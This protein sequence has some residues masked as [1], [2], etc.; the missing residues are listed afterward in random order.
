MLEELA[1]MG[2]IQY[3][4]TMLRAMPKPDIS[5]MERKCKMCGEPTNTHY[6]PICRLR[7]AQQDEGQ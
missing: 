2:K 3:A 5:D 6:C 1:P 7:R 4:H